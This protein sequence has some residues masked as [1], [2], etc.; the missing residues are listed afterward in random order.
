GI[1]DDA[2][3]TFCNGRRVGSMGSFT[4]NLQSAWN[5]KRLY[6]VPAA[7]LKPG[8]DNVLA[9]QVKDFGGLCVMFVEPYVAI[10][11]PARSVARFRAEDAGDDVANFARIDH[12]DSTWAEIPLPDPAFD[13]RQPADNAYGWYRFRF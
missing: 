13:Q 6:H 8:A 7:A 10:S 12:D 2:D 3:A 9:V 1:I 11:L 4:E 5:K